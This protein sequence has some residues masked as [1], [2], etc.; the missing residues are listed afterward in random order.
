[1]YLLAP[2]VFAAVV[3]SLLFAIGNSRAS[4]S[5]M[6]WLPGALGFLSLGVFIGCLI[7]FIL[8]L[9]RRYA[10]STVVLL[11][12]GYVIGQGVIVVA[13]FFGACVF[14]LSHA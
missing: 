11:T 14:M 10:T 4:S 8:L 2:P 6:E 1:M 5:S 12:F 13:M 3:Y 7:G 9:N